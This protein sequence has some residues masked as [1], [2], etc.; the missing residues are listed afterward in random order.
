MYFDILFYYYLSL[1]IEFNGKYFSY[2]E[3]TSSIRHVIFVDDSIDPSILN[4]I[5]PVLKAA[6]CASRLADFITEKTRFNN[7]QVVQA[8]MS[9][10]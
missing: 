1:I 5:K 7:G 9:I 2:N 4:R 10:A 6:Y 8:F 3:N